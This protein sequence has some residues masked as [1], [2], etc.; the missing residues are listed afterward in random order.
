LGCHLTQWLLAHGETVKDVRT[1]ATAR[2]REQSRG[3]GR[4]TDAL[5][6]AAA[7]GIAAMQGDAEP[8]A[9]DDGT[10]VL[11]VLEQR[12]S[13]LVGQRTRSVNQLHAESSRVLWCSW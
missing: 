3:R 6:A 7:A 11:A 1:T 10:V 13:N 4:K 8:V 12:R 9:P 2:V 5:D